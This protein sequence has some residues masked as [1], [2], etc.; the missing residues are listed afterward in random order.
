MATPDAQTPDLQTGSSGFDPRD[1]LEIVLRRW[2]WLAVGLVAGLILGAAAWWAL[3][4]RY[5][6]SISGWNEARRRRTG[7][8]S[9]GA[10]NSSPFPNESTIESTPRRSG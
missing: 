3:P 1:V 10:K 6:A 2:H 4:K 7:R 5:E 8:N 9:P